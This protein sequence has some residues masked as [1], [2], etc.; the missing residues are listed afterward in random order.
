[1]PRAVKGT[2]VQCDPSIKAIIQGIDSERH[3]FIIEELDDETLVVKESKLPELKIRIE[4]VC[5]LTMTI[6]CD[7]I[8][9]WSC[10]LEAPRHTESG[11]GCYRLRLGLSTT[12]W[13]SDF[14]IHTAKLVQTGLRPRDDTHTNEQIVRSRVAELFISRACQK[15][16]KLSIYEPYITS[17]KA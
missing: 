11:T 17:R 16:L 6:P 9:S 15:P 10:F 3:D 4:E 5:I 2:L 13:C 1:M 7:S 12:P 14:S 8:S